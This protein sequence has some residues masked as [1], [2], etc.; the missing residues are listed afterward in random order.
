MIL[1][2]LAMSTA[3]ASRWPQRTDPVRPSAIAHALDVTNGGPSSGSAGCFGSTSAL[4]TSG[5]GQA[6]PGVTPCAPPSE[7]APGSSRR[8]WRGSAI[9][10]IAIREM[11]RWMQMDTAEENERIAHPISFRFVIRIMNVVLPGR[12]GTLPG[13]PGK[14]VCPQMNA[15]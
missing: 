3:S 11:P 2:V 12:E 10:V 14:R 6:A 9:A 13:A 7:P 5:G 8:A 4:T 1:V 15:D